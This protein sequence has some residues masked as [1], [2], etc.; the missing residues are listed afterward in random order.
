[1]LVQ[2]SRNK[3]LATSH[4]KVKE[5]TENKV[6]GGMKEETEDKAMANLTDLIRGKTMATEED[7]ITTAQTTNRTTTKEKGEEEITNTMTNKK[8]S[9]GEVR[10]RLNLVI[11]ELTRSLTIT[12]LT[13]EG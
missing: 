1:M 6:T 3:D 4:T 11:K 5:E 12:I 10:K 9:E 7:S 8:T 13:T 2:E